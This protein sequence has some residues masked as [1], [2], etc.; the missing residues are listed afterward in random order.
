M[1]TNEKSICDTPKTRLMT[2][3]ESHK[4]SLSEC[5]DSTSGS[6]GRPGLTSEDLQAVGS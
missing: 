6:Q 3:S 2:L 4:D 5:S 1:H